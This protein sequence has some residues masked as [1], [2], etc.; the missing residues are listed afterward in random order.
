MVDHRLA[1]SAT[2]TPSE[3]ARLRHAA[4]T[5]SGRWSRGAFVGALAAMVAGAV[6]TAAGATAVEDVAAPVALA[7]L[8]V[9]SMAGICRSGAR[10]RGGA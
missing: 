8:A 9:G 10:R 7:L 3:I 1:A 2:R 5:R 4:A 6:G